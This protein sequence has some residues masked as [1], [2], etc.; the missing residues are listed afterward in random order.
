MFRC[1]SLIDL[2]RGP[3]LRHTGLIKAFKIIKVI[4]KFL[5]LTMSL[6]QFFVQGINVTI[7]YLKSS[8]SYW[9]G[10]ADAETLQRIYGISFLESKQLKEWEIRQEEAAKRDHRKI[11]R[12]F[13]LIFLLAH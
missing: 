7:C 11:G 1:G 10:N 9:E 2:C 3:H 6:L 13:M 4:L 5:Y 12:V 8:S